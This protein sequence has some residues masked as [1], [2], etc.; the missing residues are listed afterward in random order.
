MDSRSRPTDTSVRAPPSPLSFPLPPPESHASL[1]TG[2]GRGVD[3]L[4]ADGALLVRIQT[5]YT[6]QN[7]AWTGA[8]LQTLWL[9]GNH[10]VSKVEWD[11]KGQELR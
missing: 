2:A 4:D 11:L 5:N 10:G 7:F 1:V 8:Q 3:V 6:V 9:M